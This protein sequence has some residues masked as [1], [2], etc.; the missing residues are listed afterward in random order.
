MTIRMVFAPEAYAEALNEYVGIPFL[1]KGRDVYGADCYGL[2]CAVYSDM[3][4]IQ[5]PSFSDA[6]V[7]TQDSQALADLIH[8]NISPWRQIPAGEEKTL[9]AVLMTEG[10][11]PRHIGVVVKKG[12]VLHVENGGEACIERYRDGRL[13][14]K[15]RG[16]YRHVSQL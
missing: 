6:Y 2:L 7:T 9:D 11:V 14:H 3:L 5:L 8:G 1:E 16:F 13:K 12:Y 4:G 15:V 10:G